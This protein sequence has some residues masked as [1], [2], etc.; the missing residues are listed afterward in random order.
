M[1]GMSGSEDSRGVLS[2]FE[3]NLEEW[4]DPSSSSFSDDVQGAS[5][6]ELVSIR[7]HVDMTHTFSCLSTSKVGT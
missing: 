7:D 2:D 6:D 1:V 4:V 5:M 3:I